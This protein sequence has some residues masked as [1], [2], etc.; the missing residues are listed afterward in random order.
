MHYFQRVKKF[1]GILRLEI[2]GQIIGSI[3]VIVGII[4]LA[5][6]AEGFRH[7]F[8]TEANVFFC[9]SMIYGMFFSCDVIHTAMEL[10]E[11]SRKV[12]QLKYL[13]NIFK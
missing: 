3:Y 11:G 10:I 2:C 13:K 6:M 9:S 7:G 5:T 12:R 8:K 4:L 1:Y